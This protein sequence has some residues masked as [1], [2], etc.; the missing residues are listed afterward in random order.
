MKLKLI[1]DNWWIIMLEALLFVVNVEFGQSSVEKLIV[2]TKHSPGN[3]CN[4]THW[5]YQEKCTYLNVVWLFCDDVSFFHCCK[6]KAIP[7]NAEKAFHLTLAYHFEASQYEA[8]LAL[9][10]RVP[11]KT[12]AQWHFLLLSRDTSFHS[13]EVSAVARENI[14]E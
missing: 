4:E 5:I 6:E 2:S 1:I 10:K 8:I 13:H 11:L 9:T 7:F 12:T 14:L 3:E